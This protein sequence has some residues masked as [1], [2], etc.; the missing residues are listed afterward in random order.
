MLMTAQCAETSRSSE[1]GYVCRRCSLCCRDKR[2]QIN[3]YELARLARA[4]GETTSE[5]R[6]RWTLD[7]Q[8][9][10]LGQKEDG[11]CVF[12][13]PQ[14]CEVHADRPLVCRL[15]PLA[16]HVLTDRGE[17]FTTLEG[18]PQSKGEFTNRGTVADYLATQGAMPFLEA[19]DAYFRWLCDAHERL[20]LTVEAIRTGPDK[21]MQYDL[22][23]MDAM[24]ARHCAATGSP[25]PTE[26]LERMDL[27]LQLL[28][29]ALANR[30]DGHAEKISEREEATR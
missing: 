22:L 9:T 30:E 4:Q 17:Y 20:D 26:L 25:E 19:A 12:L 28:Y 15:Y 23:D 2:I 8:G 21:E 14:G 27:H 16:R 5:F 11:T 3:P 1:F 24:I 7:G 13:G 29:A 18:H 10:T 6:K